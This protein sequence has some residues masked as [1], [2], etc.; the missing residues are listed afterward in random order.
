MELHSETIV[1]SRVS[2]FLLNNY[3]HWKCL[4]FKKQKLFKR[5]TLAFIFLILTHHG[6]YIFFKLGNF[7]NSEFLS[8]GP[9]EIFLVYG[10]HLAANNNSLLFGLPIKLLACAVMLID[11]VIRI[12][13]L[14][15]YFLINVLSFTNHIDYHQRQEWRYIQNK[16][17]GGWGW[18]WVC[19]IFFKHC[20]GNCFW[21][22]IRHCFSRVV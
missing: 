19:L 1:S 22:I 9:K 17:K 3:L 21:F 14:L 5:L 8:N 12:Y 6:K 13:H 18:G 4:Y 16:N 20:D 2:Y 11:E 15:C 7:G 10:Q